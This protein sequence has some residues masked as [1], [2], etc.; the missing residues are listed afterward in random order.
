MSFKFDDETGIP[1]LIVEDNGV[2]WQRDETENAKEQTGLG[3]LVVEQLCMQFGEKPVYETA[4][5]GSGTRV[6]V[7][8][9]S[10]AST[11]E[12]PETEAAG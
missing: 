2:G 7:R 4:E 3:T 12:D 6:I 5:S 9:S 1:A 11:K 8:L 10:L